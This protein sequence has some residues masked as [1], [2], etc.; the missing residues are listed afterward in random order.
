MSTDSFGLD[1]RKWVE[2]V[3]DRAD[4]T[5]KKTVVG[6]AAKVDERS[7]VGDPKNWIY[8]RGTKE[9]PDYVDYLAY[10]D[11]PAGYAGG[12]FRGNWQLKVGS[13]PEGEID[14]V[15]PSGRATQSAI[16]AVIPTEAA[17]LIYYLANNLPYAQALENGHSGQAPTGVV[18]LTVLEFQG[19]VD[20]AVAD[21]KQARP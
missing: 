6:L 16:A 12:R 15:D 7:P 17:G 10:R 1:L 3:K 13:M 21:A 2:K 14:R 5:V 19:F 11:P 20:K 9:A 8:N 18:G 4:L